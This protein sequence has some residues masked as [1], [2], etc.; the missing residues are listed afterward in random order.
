M[1]LP[2][3]PVTTL[4]RELR[5]EVRQHH[6]GG[7]LIIAVDGFTTS[8]TAAF[9]DTFAQVLG[10]DGT[11]VLRASVDGFRVPGSA[12]LTAE[13]TDVET[14]HRVLIDPWRS[15]VHTS[16]STGVQLAVWDPARSAPVPARWVTAPADAVLVI[17]GPFLNSPEL[18]GA[19]NF[20]IWLE[21]SEAR[22]AERPGRST[23]QPYTAGEFA[24]LRTQPLRAAAAI[25]DNGDP[26]APVQVY[27][28]FC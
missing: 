4:M 17:D 13:D 22:L 9:A 27:R 2:I 15:G 19:W 18:R 1:R 6:P 20:S 23:E 14:L 3:T 21:V 8:G 12:G 7:R 25:I 10:E 24:Y 26:T 28:D 5:Q 16:D 11:A